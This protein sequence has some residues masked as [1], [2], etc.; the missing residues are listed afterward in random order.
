VPFWRSP[1]DINITE[2]IYEEVA[3]IYG[4]EKIDEAPLLSEFKNVPYT[5]YISLNRKLEEVL[6]RN[7]GFV[8]TET[9]PWVSEKVVKDL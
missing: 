3:R 7:L 9:Y 6:V 2:D 4:Y 8:Q 1:D 5:P